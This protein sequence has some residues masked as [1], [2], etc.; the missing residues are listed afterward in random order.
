M[1]KK[2]SEIIKEILNSVLA[3][4]ERCGKIVIYWNKMGRFFDH[5]IKIVKDRR[6]HNNERFILKNP[7]MEYEIMFHTIKTVKINLMIDSEGVDFF[8]DRDNNRPTGGSFFYIPFT[9]LN[10]CELE[11]LKNIVNLNKYTTIIT[12]KISRHL[13]KFTDFDCSGVS[14]QNVDYWRG[15]LLKRM[16]T[17]NLKS[18]VNTSLKLSRSF[19]K[20][21]SGSKLSNGHEFKM[22]KYYYH[23]MICKLL[24][25][26]R[27]V[28]IKSFII[29]QTNKYSNISIIA[30]NV[31]KMLCDHITLHAQFLSEISEYQNI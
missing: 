26:F 9:F 1:V 7:S 23:I 30:K 25:K 14:I 19:V 31:H 17:F 18:M 11:M 21:L 27:T 28:L 6:S 16:V 22:W 4:N 2:I 10:F 8:F 13:C 29:E 20:N 24:I 15:I 12:N 5:Q 3:D